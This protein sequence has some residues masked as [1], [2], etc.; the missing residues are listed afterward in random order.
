M[1]CPWCVDYDPWRAPVK[2]STF[3]PDNR[4]NACKRLFPENDG[5]WQRA[6]DALTERKWGSFSIAMG[7]AEGIPDRVYVGFAGENS[8]QQIVRETVKGLWRKKRL[9]AALP[10]DEQLR[11]FKLVCSQHPAQ[12]FGSPQPAGR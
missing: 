4:C 7:N 12:V 1:I 5:E 8:A 3:L 11:L 9:V 6:F 10:R 2:E